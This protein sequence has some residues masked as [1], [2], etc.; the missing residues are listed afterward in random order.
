MI[1]K[2]QWRSLLRTLMMCHL[3][4]SPV[5]VR[6]ANSAPLLEDVS[7]GVFPAVRGFFTLFDILLVV[8]IIFLFFQ[9]KRHS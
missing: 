5:F 8:L 1:R 6:H 4:L 2:P 9:R 3:S 7:N